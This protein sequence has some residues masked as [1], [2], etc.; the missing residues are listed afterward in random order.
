MRDHPTAGR[1]RA[2]FARQRLGLVGAACAVVAVA[3]GIGIRRDYSAIP[4]GQIGFDDLCGLQDYFDTIEA[5]LAK[6]P[7][8]VSAVDIEAQSNKPI[9]GG[10]NRFSF[11]TDFQLKHLLRVLNENWSRLPESLAT[12]SRIDLEVHWSEKAGVRRVVTEGDSELII[13]TESFPLPYHVCLSEL[14]YGEP[15]YHQ[16]R[17]MTGRPLPYKS[18]LGDAG[19][20]GL[21]A[22]PQET[23]RASAA[24]DGGRDV[25]SPATPLS[26]PAA[27]PAP[28]PAA[29]PAA[30][31][32][33]RAGRADG[34]APTS[35]ARPQF[36]SAPPAQ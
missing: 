2:A 15:L 13:K 29:G 32:P 4:A 14:L 33:P 35:P 7:P 8:I 30:A 10:K 28:A 21:A 3:C 5:R 31:P 24:A 27:P 6:A 26:A 34:G 22:P 20:A 25:G 11:E 12:A 36:K 16:R 17:E 18:L 23:A 9:R 1:W 19:L